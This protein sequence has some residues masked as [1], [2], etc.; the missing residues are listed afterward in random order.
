MQRFAFHPGTVQSALVNNEGL[1]STETAKVRVF[2]CRERDC[3]Y[4][5]QNHFPRK[6]IEFH[7]R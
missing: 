7:E 4:W 3:G 2:N 1:F 5:I 6:L